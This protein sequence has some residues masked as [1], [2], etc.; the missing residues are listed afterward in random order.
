MIKVGTAVKWKW[1]SGIA[2]GKV[3]EIF[4]K[5]I[6]KT[7]TGSAISRKASPENKSFLIEQEDGAKVLKSATEI[8]R[9]E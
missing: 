5:D 2:T 8:E 1:G 4:T 3:V 9:A 7:I 6:I